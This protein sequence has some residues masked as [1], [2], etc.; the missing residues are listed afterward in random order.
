MARSLTPP[1]GM[2]DQIARAIATADVAEFENDPARFG[3][4]AMA[5]LR[6]LCSPT[7]PMVDAAHEA[8]SFD[9]AWA[10]NSRSDFRKAV[11]AMVRAA[12][13]EGR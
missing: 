8:V 9:D 2:V 4:L 3:K 6:P 13:K 12:I 10:I 11:R 5:S 1:T 7:D